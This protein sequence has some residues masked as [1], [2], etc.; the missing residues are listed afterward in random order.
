MELLSVIVPIYNVEPWLERCVRSILGQTYG[1]LEILLVDDGST[2]GCPALCDRFG[3]EDPRVRVIHK[4]NGGLSDA[5]NAG[6][7]MASGT[8]LAFV[9]G[10]DWIDAGMYEA[11]MGALAK[12]GADLC[13]CSYK[14]IRRDG[15]LDPSTGKR[16]VWEGQGM[17]EAFLLELDEYQIQNSAWNKVYKRE[18]LGELRF[19]KGKLYEDIVFTTK[20]LSR[21]RKGVYL[22][23]AF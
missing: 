23:Q 15:V 5:R 22:D 6:I 18:L 19:P 20:L 14:R 8:C 17:L 10:D 13:A 9:D 16:T 3:E 2:D 12:E 21:V 4:K 1:N 7:D 11:M